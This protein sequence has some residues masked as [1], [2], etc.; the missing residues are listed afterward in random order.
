[1]G[2]IFA[3]IMTVLSEEFRI[4]GSFEKN[5]SRAPSLAVL[6]ELAAAASSFF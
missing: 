2:K 1:M 3:K 4:V 5:S 6:E